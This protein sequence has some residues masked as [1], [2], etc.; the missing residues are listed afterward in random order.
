MFEMKDDLHPALTSGL[1]TSVKPDLTSSRQNFILIP[2]RVV[3]V[4][5]VNYY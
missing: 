3:Q 2:F 1:I 5:S 4:Y